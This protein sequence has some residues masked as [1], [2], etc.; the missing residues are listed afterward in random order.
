MEKNA[1]Q[2]GWLVESAQRM[3]GGAWLWDVLI[4]VHPIVGIVAS[5]VLIIGVSIGLSLATRRMRPCICTAQSLRA[6]PH[7]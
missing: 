7:T 5:C 2:A 6:W 4:G 1:W 3:V